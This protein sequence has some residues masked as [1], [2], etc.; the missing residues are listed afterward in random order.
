MSS[1][2]NLSMTGRLAA[3]Q[4]DSEGDYKALVCLFLAGGNDSFNMLVPYSGDARVDYEASRRTV[5]LPATELL[6]LPDPLPDGRELG[7][8]EKMPELHSLYSAGKA[9]FV[10]N[11]GS[12]IEPTTQSDFNAGTAKLPLGLF[13]HSDQSVHWQ[14]TLPD[15]RSPQSGWGGRLSDYLSDL[16]GVSKVSMNVSLSGLNVFQS[17]G[18]SAALAIS[19][20]GTL[21]IQDWENASFAHRRQATESILDAEYQNAFERTFVNLRKN[22]IEASEEFTGALAAQS[23]LGEFFS[24]S[25]LSQELRTVARTIA[26]RGTLNKNRQTFFVEFGG[27]DLHGSS[28]GHSALLE[29]LSKSIGEFQAAMA[30]LETEEEVTLFTCSDFGR[31]LTPN[32][33]GTDHAWGG[34][35]FVVGGA[36]SGGRVLGDYPDLALNTVLDAGRG[37]LIP[38]TS[39]D[40]YYGDLALWMGVPSSDL[41]FVLP[42]LHR[43]WDVASGGQPLGIFSTE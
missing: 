3:D 12:L 23:D 40:E 6:A 33:N 28:G 34:N 16:N 18:G 38:T 25:E 20:S 39:V 9:A 27:W 42:N 37:R 29:Q 19:P 7:I 13:S 14:S 32:G 10:S 30:F 43:F 26:S 5:A 8:Q 21:A 4:S 11:V 24:S 31:T 1:L 17:G 22:A 36:V 2:L 41:G 15:Q 35:Q